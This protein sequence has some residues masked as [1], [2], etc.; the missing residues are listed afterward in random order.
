[1]IGLADLWT[2]PIRLDPNWNG[3]DYYGR[4]P[5]SAGLAQALKLV[6]LTGRHW[7]WAARTYGH[8]PGKAGPG[9]QASIA[10][11]F[12]IVE[13]LNEVGAAR[14]ALLD[15]NSMFYMSRAAALY[16]LTDAEIDGIRAK[17]LFVPASSDLLFPPELSTQALERFRARG[18]RGELFVLQGDGGHLDGVFE[19]EQAAPT[20][21]RFL[22]TD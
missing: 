17:I 16:R 20:I 15:A 21:R 3:G 19:I 4:T 11:E 22:T 12:R 8:A 1:V 6:T 10:S 18:G 14:A 5:P 7:G 9:P 13:S 2:T